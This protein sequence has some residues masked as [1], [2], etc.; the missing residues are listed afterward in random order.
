MR[1][2][3]QNYAIKGDSEHYAKVV[4]FTNWG[5]RYVHFN[6][7][8]YNHNIAFIK[9]PANM[10]LQDFKKFIDKDQIILPI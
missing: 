9:E 6:K 1:I 8:N 3:K 4:R 2:G 10:P 7:I 5:G